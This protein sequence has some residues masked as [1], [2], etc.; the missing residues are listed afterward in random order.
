MSQIIERIRERHGLAGKPVGVVAAFGKSVEVKE[1][2]RLITVV[3]NTDDVDLDREVVVPAGADVS[4]MLAN[5][6]V[7]VDH[8]YD[9][10]STV[11][12]LRTLT[13]WP[14]AKDHRAWKAVVSMFKLPGNPLPD[15]ILE[16]ARTEGIGTSIGFD[17]IEFGSPTPD[18]LQRFTRRGVS[19]DR[20][21]RRWRMLEFSFTQIPCNVACQSE[22]ERVDDS[23][24][25]RIEA[26]VGKGRITVESAQKFGI[27]LKSPKPKRRIVIV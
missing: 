26:L 3:I 4:Y 20:I 2:N 14:S 10:G 22:R 16:M 13:P 6:S 12:K 8:R 15:D 25:A 9:I 11:G 18:E 17:P 1:D 27:G 24:A 23:R 5:R 7:F 21:Y 19:P